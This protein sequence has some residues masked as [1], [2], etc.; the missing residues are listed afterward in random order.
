M[1]PVQIAGEL[2]LSASTVYAVLVRCRLNRL[3]NAA[4][5]ILLA[6]R[7]RWPR[8][9]YFAHDHFQRPNALPSSRM[10]TLANTTR[11]RRRHRQQPTW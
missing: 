9:V 8:I 5:R 2:G 7:V 11:Y 4:P 3:G 1:G 10:N 6:A